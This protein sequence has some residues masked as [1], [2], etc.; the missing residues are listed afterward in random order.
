M[1]HKYKRKSRKSRKTN[2]RFRFK[3][4]CSCSVYFLYGKDV[5]DKISEKLFNSN[6]LK[7]CVGIF[8]IYRN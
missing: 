8:K 1:V 3:I 6:T 7:L 4:K 2:Q 5:F